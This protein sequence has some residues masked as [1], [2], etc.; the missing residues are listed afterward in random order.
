MTDWTGVHCRSRMRE[1]RV[2]AFV[3]LGEARL[4][5]VAAISAE[6]EGVQVK[7][8]TTLGGVVLFLASSEE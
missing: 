7:L 4:E 6:E 5:D 2:F 8:S 3:G 1:W